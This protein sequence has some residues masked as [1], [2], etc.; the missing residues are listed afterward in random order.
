MGSTTGSTLDESEDTCVICLSIVTEKALTV[1]CNHHAFD[2]VCLIS[3]LQERSTCPLCKTEVTAVQYDWQSPTDFKSYPVRRSHPPKN[4]PSNVSTRPS[5]FAPYGLPRRPRGGRRPY[6]P[7]IEDV[8]LRGRREVYQR[9]LYSL[10]VGSNRFSG[11]RDITPQMVAS[12]PD[13]QSKARA[14]IRRELRVFTFLHTDPTGSITNESTTSSNAE[15]LLS[16]IVS[17]LKMV[18]IKA[19]SGHAENLLAE[20]LGRENS[21]LFLHELNAWL[22]SPY[23]KVEEWDLNTQYAEDIE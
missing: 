17:I 5:L 20:F 15:F 14:W 18:D 3:W 16:Y 23:T 9:N 7:P 2:F 1:P 10:H 13:L 6:S 22:R 4:I 19:S 11:Y 8:A 12:S 21:R